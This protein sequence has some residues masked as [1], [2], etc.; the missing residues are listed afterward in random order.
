VGTPQGFLVIQS[1]QTPSLDEE[2]LKK[3]FED[4]KKAALEQKRNEAFNAFFE[5]LKIQA[6]LVS[7]V[8]PIGRYGT[9]VPAAVEE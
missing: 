5:G 9:P 8:K 1:L 2:K 6:H 3:E 7:Y 4:F